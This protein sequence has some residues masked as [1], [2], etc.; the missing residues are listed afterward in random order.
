MKKISAANYRGFS[1]D[2]V[3]NKGG[4]L[5]PVFL[6]SDID[7]NPSNFH[8]WKLNKL[9]PTI[10]D[11]KRAEL[12]IVDVIWIEILKSMKNLGCNLTSMKAVNK[13]LFEDSYLNHHA[14][15]NLKNNLIWLIE[16]EKLRP[17]NSQE[18]ITKTSI[19]NTMNDPLLRN[20]FRWAISHLYTLVIDSIEHGANIRIRLFENG[21]VKVIGNTSMLSIETTQPHE[22]GQEQGDTYVQISLTAIV[23]RFFGD[24]NI[25]KKLSN[26]GFLTT[27]ELMVIEEMRKKNIKTL[28]IHFDDVAKKI[29]KIECDSAGMIEGEKAIEVMKILGMK[30]YSGIELN[31]RNGKSLSFIRTEKKF[32]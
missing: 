7:V 20:Y 5:E 4:L 14:E 11:G 9:L 3:S 8:Y 22:Q 23:D 18:Q 17:L 19:V 2:A 6:R 29:K 13:L 25:E 32:F 21:L 12:S 16:Q 26:S 1:V 31:T 30:N 15:K 28:T 24:R 10:P 27:E